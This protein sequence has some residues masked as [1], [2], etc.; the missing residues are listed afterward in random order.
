[1]IA[2]RL[3]KLEVRAAGA[4]AARRARL[5]AEDHER[6]WPVDITDPETVSLA[7]RLH[8][9]TKP[10]ATPEFAGLP[11]AEREAQTQATARR[12]R[13]RVEELRLQRAA[14]QSSGPGVFR[15]NGATAAAQATE[16]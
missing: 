7:R 12:L 4:E 2:R 14:A 13:G 5:E 15:S 10:H 6:D 16:G 8:D 1:M 11:A 3:A 9:L